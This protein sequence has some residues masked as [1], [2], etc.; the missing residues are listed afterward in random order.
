MTSQK[1]ASATEATRTAACAPKKRYCMVLTKYMGSG[2]KGQKRVGSGITAP[3]SGITTPGIG[4]SGIFHWTR[5]RRSGSTK[6]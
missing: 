3:G 2:I 4:I 5:I 1:T 6:F